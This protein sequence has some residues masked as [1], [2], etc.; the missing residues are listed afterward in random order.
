MPGYVLVQPPPI[1]PWGETTPQPQHRTK[2][3]YLE[4]TILGQ[5]SPRNVGIVFFFLAVLKSQ[6]SIAEAALNFTVARVSVR[7]NFALSSLFATQIILF[8]VATQ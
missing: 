1:S 2:F 3:Q 8:S 4:A 7:I 5:I 6:A